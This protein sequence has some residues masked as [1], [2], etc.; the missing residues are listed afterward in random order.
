MIYEYNQRAVTVRKT[1][2]LACVQNANFELAIISETRYSQQ[3]PE[4]PCRRGE[5]GKADLLHR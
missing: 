3:R 1:R 2:Q 4:L 5:I